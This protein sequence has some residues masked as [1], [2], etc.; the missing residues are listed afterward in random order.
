MD[1]E[2][3]IAGVPLDRP[4]IMGILNV[5]PDSFSDGGR[6]DH[7]DA[8]VAHA[9]QMKADGADIIDIGGESTRPGSDPVSLDDELARVIP[10]IERLA[11]EGLG[12][13]SIDTRKSQVMS[14][15]V[16]AGAAIINDVSALSYDPKALTVAAAFKVPVILMHA[17]GDPKTMQDAPTYS[18]V[19]AEVFGYL[20]ERIAACEAAG[21]GRDLIIAD[22]GIGFGKTLDHNLALLANLVRFRELDVPLLLGA[23]RKRFISMI[24]PDAPADQRIGGS[25]AAVAV[26]VR[27]DVQLFRVH[28]VKETAQFL[29]IS[30]AISSNRQ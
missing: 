8:A 12:P 3:T 9:R 20:Q 26:G 29:A 15:A 30:D 16:K 6:F 17:Q 28:D 18:D 14:A 22:P 1:Y 25:L 10:V 24:D 4:R 11:A 27:A 2:I 5:T 13:L 7:L 19:V 23:S 21:I